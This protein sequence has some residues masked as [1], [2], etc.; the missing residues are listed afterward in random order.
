MPENVGTESGWKF[1]ASR[2]FLSGIFYWTGFD[3]RGEPTPYT[4]P[5]I[6]SQFGQLDL[7]GYPKDIFYYLKSWWGTEPVLHLAPHWTFPGFE[8]K[9][10]QVTV[11]SNCDE[12]ELFVNSKSAGRQN[13]PVNG[14]LDWNVVYRPGAIKAVGYK[15]G[16]K[17]LTMQHETVSDPVALRI[18]ADRYALKSG[19]ADVAI[20]DVRFEDKQGRM[21]PTANSTVHFDI[22]GPGRIIGVGNGDPSSHD[23]EC[24]A[25]RYEIL[26]F[27]DLRQKAVNSLESRPEVAGIFD[28]SSWP[29]AFYEPSRLWSDHSDSLL[30]VRGVFEIARLEEATKVVLLSKSI[31]ENQVIYV[32]G[33]AVSAQIKRDAIGQEFVL[34]KALVH[35]GKNTIAFVGERIRKKYRWDEPNTHPGVVQVVTPAERAYRKTFMGHAQVLVQT[36]GELG[37]IVVKATSDGI[38][39]AS[40]VLSAIK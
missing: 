38:K 39:T 26:P 20:L 27:S 28:A 1:Y 11:F 2:P 19:S 32:N 33:K 34:D 18:S 3:Y 5:A 4:W 40:S 17:T 31:L 21:D 12:V 37:T 23:P 29:I 25:D 10:M 16:K 6:C 36:T 14:H 9:E 15:N 13:M 24:F 30:V 7:C 35:E 8:G 22:S